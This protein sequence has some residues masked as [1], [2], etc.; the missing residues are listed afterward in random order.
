MRIRF[1]FEAILVVAALAALVAS[2]IFASI[3][4]QWPGDVAGIKALQSL[5]NSVSKPVTWGINFLGDDPTQLGLVGAVAGWLVYVGRLRLAVLLAVVMIIETFLVMDLKWLV[6]RPSP[7]PGA[8]FEILG[9][10]AKFAFPSGHVAFAG[11]FFGTLV[12]LVNCHL[13][14][15]KWM[16][17][18][19]IVVLCIP[20]V[21]MGPSRIAWGIHW[22]SD[23]L[24]GYLVVMLGIVLVRVAHRRFV[25]QPQGQNESGGI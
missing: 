13:R 12:Y 4:Q 17:R 22:P 21:L 6:Q 11:L 10:T 15:S 25:G 3:W 23:V 19:L 24:G 5:L 2:S 7:Q 9:E 20:I 1:G 18:T 14:S 8:D 16:R